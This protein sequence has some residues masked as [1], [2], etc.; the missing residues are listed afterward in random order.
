MADRYTKSVLT[1][2]AAALCMIATQQFLRT[3]EAETGR[4]GD[5]SH[6]CATYNVYWESN[7]SQWIPCY[8]TGRSCYAVG[9]NNR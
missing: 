6:P 8:G 1:V 9:T 3:A 2:I 5:P 7:S 4:C